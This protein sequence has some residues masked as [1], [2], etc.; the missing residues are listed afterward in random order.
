[1]AT[2]ANTIE[3][4][5]KTF[6]KDITKFLT[7]KRAKK[8][9]TLGEDKLVTATFVYSSRSVTRNRSPQ[10]QAELISKGSSW[11]PASAHMIDM[12]RHVDLMYGAPGK[13]AKISWDLKNA[14]GTK[15]QNFATM[16]ELKAKWNSLMKTHKLKNYAGKDGWSDSDSFHFELADSKVPRNDP[17]I[18]ECLAHYARITRINGKKK[19][20]SFETGSW[21]TALAPHLKKVEAELA[22]TKEEERKKEL[23]NLK[24][25]GALKK[26]R[27]LLKNANKSGAAGGRSLGDI[28]P[29]T[30]EDTGKVTVKKIQVNNE[31]VWDSLGRSVFE[32]LGLAESS[33]FDIKLICGVSFERVEHALLSQSFVQNVIPSCVLTYNTPVAF[34]MKM[35]TKVTSDLNLT[36]SAK[37]VSGTIVFDVT[38]STPIDKENGKITMTVKDGKATSQAKLK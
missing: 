22:K 32:K 5:V 38:L 8:A 15:P 11:T 37:G 10:T 13:K 4:S 27:S 24:F 20:T 34:A 31:L 19:N 17:K 14:F 2:T 26:S 12:A 21:K 33:G 18:A 6:A 35:T 1:M 3:T 7:D 25:T 9:K 23:A 28:L 30:A 36:K 16:A 29:D